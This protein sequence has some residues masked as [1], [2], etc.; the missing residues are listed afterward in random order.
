MMNEKPR[1]VHA[2][3]HVG[4][5]ELDALEG[6]DRLAELL[7]LL[8]VAG[9]GVERGL[10]DADGER[11]GGRP[12]D[13]ER[14]HGDLEAL[15]LGAETLLDRD[16]AVGEVQRHGGRGADAE[17][18][19]LLA[20]LEARRPL[21]DEERRDPPGAPRR[22][23]RREHG[24][25]VRV[26]AVGAPLLRAVEH[27]TVAAPQRRRL[28]PGRV[29]AG[30]GL[31]QRVGREQLAGGQ[32]RQVLLLLLLGAGQQDRQPAQRLVEILR[33]R[34]GAG[35]RDL[36]AHQRQGQAAHVAAAVGLGHPDRI[37][38]GLDDR[39]DRLLRVRLQLVVVGGMGRDPLARQLAGEVA[40][41]PLLVRQV[42]EVAHGRPMV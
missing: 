40:D 1:A 3:R 4:Q 28:E 36:L 29:G 13:V 41:H 17:L 24:D 31:G 22:I 21:L 37:E 33:A 6:G 9:G 16:G 39:L 5:H 18:A 25:D 15:A 20:D 8:G 32:P 38:P 26:A 19:L 35:R 27:V 23:H 30:G 10:G 34:R 7:A 12:R 2:D 11:A 42:E 14:R